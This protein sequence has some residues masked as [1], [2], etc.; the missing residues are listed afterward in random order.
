MQFLDLEQD[1]D[2]DN[3]LKEAVKTF[4]GFDGINSRWESASKMR[5]WI[6][7]HKKILR[8]KIEESAKKESAGKN[9]TELDAIIDKQYDEEMSDMYVKVIKKAEF[10]V[11]LSVPDEFFAKAPTK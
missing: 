3:K 10:L 4:P 5:S 8:E 9:E 6:N 7:D 11:K 1:P 2:R